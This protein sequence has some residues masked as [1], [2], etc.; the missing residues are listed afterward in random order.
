[1]AFFV[2]NGPKIKLFE[3]GSR[4]FIKKAINMN[5]ENKG[6]EEGT[7]DRMEVT[8]IYNSDSNPP[9]PSFDIEKAIR[10]KDTPYNNLS[11]SGN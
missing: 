8:T 10:E 5:D 6:T 1:M 11:A 7:E 3:I 2:E 4:Q 9:P